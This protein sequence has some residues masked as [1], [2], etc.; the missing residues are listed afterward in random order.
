[1]PSWI[2]DLILGPAYTIGN[3]IW[4]IAMTMITGVVGTTPE[5]FSAETWTFVVNILY[6]WSLGIGILLLNTFF[7]VGFLRSHS[8][9]KTNYT[10]EILVNAMIKVVMANTLMRGGIAL[11]RAFFTMAAELSVQVLV[12]QP[13]AFMPEDKDFGTY[14]FFFI[15]GVIYAL[16]AIVCAILMLLSVYG[17]YL[18]LYVLIV[19]G[20]IALSTW[21]GG[22][23]IE[24]SAYAWIKTFLS[25]TF[26]I[27]V[28]ALII[29]IGGRLIHS[30]DMGTMISG[31]GQLVDGFGAVIQS[32]IHILL[33]TGAVKGAERL[34]KQG[35]QL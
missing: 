6:P 28:I 17:R 9:L 23:G 5:D 19:F 16:V 20:P 26:E 8:D 7:L 3:T 1:M 25:N 10:M 21:A 31:I 4:Q 15:F 32:L 13:A 22:K 29:S 24:N 11:M 27:V 18:K 34:L 2:N 33:M 14:L 35:F 30:I 12:A